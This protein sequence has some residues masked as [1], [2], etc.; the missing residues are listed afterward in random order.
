MFS[1]RFKFRL[2]LSSRNWEPLLDSSI[3]EPKIVVGAESRVLFVGHDDSIFAMGKGL[4]GKD[5]EGWIRKIE[6]PD[7]CI[8]IEK[9]LYFGKF[10]LILTKDGKIFVNG[11]GFD[12][13]LPLV[14]GKCTCSDEL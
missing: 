12:Q 11:E 6:T 1:G 5:D 13:V 7:D 9:V 3:S 10:G 2:E 4:L 14:E 8:D